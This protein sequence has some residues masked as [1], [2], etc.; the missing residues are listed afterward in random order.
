MKARGSD[1]CILNGTKLKILK[2]LE[3]RQL[4]HTEIRD[5]TDLSFS[6]SYYHLMILIDFGFI[7][8]RHELVPQINKKK[9]KAVWFFRL[10]AKGYD[11]VRYFEAKE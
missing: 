8:R 3:D 10:T 11:A 7:T 5:L 2:V 1:Y 6:N 4:K 9:E